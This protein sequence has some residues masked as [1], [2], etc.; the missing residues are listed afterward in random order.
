MDKNY[1]LIICGKGGSGKSYLVKELVSKYNYNYGCKHTTRPPR[2]NEMNNIDY[3]YVD[4]DVFDRMFYDKKFICSQTFDIKHNNNILKW[5][6]GLSI[7]IFNENNLFIL[8]PLDIKQIKNYGINNNII[9]VYLDIDIK[10]RYYRLVERND[11]S[12]SIMRRLYSDEVDFYNFNDYDI[13]IK[14]P[15]FSVDDIICEINRIL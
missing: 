3:I 11:N 6:Y 9:I 5:K 13:V 8:T 4:D 7:D 14:N 12:D 10:K 2:K 15:D 1:K